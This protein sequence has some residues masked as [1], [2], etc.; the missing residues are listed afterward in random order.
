MGAKCETRR[1]PRETW[2][3]GAQRRPTLSNLSTRQ[4]FPVRKS[5]TKSDRSRGERVLPTVFYF[6]RG[7]CLNTASLH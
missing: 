3:G 5:E 1:G 6:D 7:I 4:T 2:R